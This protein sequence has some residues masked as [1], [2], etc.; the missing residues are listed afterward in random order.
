MPIFNN[1]RSE[2]NWSETCVTILKESITKKFKDPIEIRIQQ[3]PIKKNRVPAAPIKKY[4]KAASA[5]NAE[6]LDIPDKVYK[7]NDCSSNAIKT[8]SKS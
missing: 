3:Q 4:F 2:L 5:L 1:F 7:Q 8:K 6:V